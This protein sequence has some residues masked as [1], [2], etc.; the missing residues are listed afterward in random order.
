MV[1][2]LFRVRNAVQQI[3]PCTI[4]LFLECH[5]KINTFRGLSGGADGAGSPSGSALS[6]SFVGVFAGVVRKS[7]NASGLSA[8]EGAAT[9][10]ACVARIVMHRAGKFWR[11]IGGDTMR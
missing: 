6:A 8:G 3:E 1:V 7:G 4:H 10:A 11:R 9:H 2:N 5:R